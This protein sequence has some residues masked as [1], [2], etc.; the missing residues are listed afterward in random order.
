MKCSSYGIFVH[1][2]MHVQ[3]NYNVNCACIPGYQNFAFIVNRAKNCMV[4]YFSYLWHKLVWVIKRETLCVRELPCILAF[5][6]H[7]IFFSQSDVRSDMKDIS[8]FTDNFHFFD[9]VSLFK[10]KRS[11][12][13][14]VK[15]EQF[16]RI[17]W[18][19]VR[20]LFFQY[21]KS[22]ITSSLFD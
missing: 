5:Y 14:A 3:I 6:A 13:L 22:Y 18:R 10:C 8:S 4:M 21:P 20:S 11:E 2:H 19:E 16:L 1:V 9:K 12:S 7:V 15:E 17:C